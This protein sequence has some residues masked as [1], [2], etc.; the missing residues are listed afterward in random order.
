MF[1][2]FNEVLYTCLTPV[3]LN[4]YLGLKRDDIL[5][6]SKKLAIDAEDMRRRMLETEKLEFLINL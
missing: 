2:A 5:E 3:H 4:F 6:K 1:F